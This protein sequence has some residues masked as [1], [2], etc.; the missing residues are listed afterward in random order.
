MICSLRKF[1]LENEI[2]NFVGKEI[3][4][5]DFDHSVYMAPS[6]RSLLGWIAGINDGSEAGWRLFLYCPYLYGRYDPVP[7][8]HEQVKSSE[9]AWEA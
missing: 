8:D 5:H 9:W 3:N 2:C 4:I 1:Y 7:V 6:C